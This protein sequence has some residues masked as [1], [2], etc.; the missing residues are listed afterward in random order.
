MK[1]KFIIVVAVLA[2][3]ISGCSET[4]DEPTEPIVTTTEATEATTAPVI[5]RETTVAT[6]TEE[7]TTTEMTTTEATTTTEEETTVVTTEATTA[8]VTTPEPVATIITEAQTSPPEEKTTARTS[9]PV[10]TT[11]APVTTVEEEYKG[12][13]EEDCLYIISECEKYMEEKGYDY[14]NL[15]EGYEKQEMI[16]ARYM[17]QEEMPGEYGHLFTF[18]TWHFSYRNN[19]SQKQTKEY[20]I[21]SLIPC[22]DCQEDDHEGTIIIDYCTN[23]AYNQWCWDSEGVIKGL[24]E[25]EG[26]YTFIICVQ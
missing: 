23:K 10:Q 9:A 15:I 2:I 4:S 3:A 12:F 1:E 13:T 21:E 6:T 26:L 7:I 25:S 18:S 5:T 24:D 14:C 17:K 11:T 19:T 20:V 8:P 16:Y 22:L